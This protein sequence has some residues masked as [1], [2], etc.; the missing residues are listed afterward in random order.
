MIVPDEHL[1]FYRLCGTSMYSN[2]LARFSSHNSRRRG[3]G[4]GGG[5]GGGEE[6]EGGGGRGRRAGGGQKM[7]LYPYTLSSW[8]WLS[9]RRNIGANPIPHPS[10]LRAVMFFNPFKG[11]H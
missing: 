2:V 4:G 8:P 6:G 9:C 1:H 3:R 5:R 7:K 10:R 11:E